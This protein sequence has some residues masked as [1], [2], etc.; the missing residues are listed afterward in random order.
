MQDANA[1]AARLRGRAS[2]PG[3]KATGPTP[4]NK[5]VL[6]YM[7]EFFAENDQL[8]PI[9]TISQHFGWASTQAAQAHADALVRHG[10]LE[11]NAVGKL[12]FARGVR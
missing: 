7:R 12:R 3:K 5:D 1:I 10:L 6:A 9:A 11:R 2:P 8:P 4:R